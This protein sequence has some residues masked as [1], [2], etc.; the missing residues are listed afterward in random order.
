[1]GPT[2]GPP[3]SCWPQMVPHV[4]P[5]NFAIWVYMINQLKGGLALNKWLAIYEPMLT[6]FYDDT[7]PQLVNVVK[8]W[9]NYVFSGAGMVSVPDIVCIVEWHKNKY[10]NIPWRYMTWIDESTQNNLQCVIIILFTGLLVSPYLSV[11]FSVC[12]QNCVRSVSSTILIGSISYLHILS[13]NFRRC[14][15]C[16]VY[17]KIQKFEISTNSLNL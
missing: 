14:V 4:G 1:M 5:M 13:S 9:D 7:S 16:K 6:Q 2:W 11:R 12:G 10:G 8:V 15:A 17:Y 3:G